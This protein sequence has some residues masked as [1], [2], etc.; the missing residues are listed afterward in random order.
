MSVKKTNNN[1][2]SVIYRKKIVYLIVI[3][4]LVDC[5]FSGNTIPC[6][7]AT[8]LL[9]HPAVNG[10][11]P[12]SSRQKIRDVL[13]EDVNQKQFGHLTTRPRCLLKVSTYG[14]PVPHTVSLLS[15][16]GWKSVSSRRSSIVYVEPM[17]FLIRALEI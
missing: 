8:D 16:L 17:S 5:T 2:M 13:K 7:S 1:L 4:N 6:P 10:N 11:W 14:D 12:F 9:L 15:L 3:S